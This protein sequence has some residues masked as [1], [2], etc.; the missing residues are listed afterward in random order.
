MLNSLGAFADSII[1][2][3]DKLVLDINAEFSSQN[4]RLVIV[5]LA[6]LIF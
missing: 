3:P 2:G 1:A 4:F 5:L 6:F